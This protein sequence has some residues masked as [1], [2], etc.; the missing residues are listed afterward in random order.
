VSQ[1]RVGCAD[2]PP[3][4]VRERF[5][6]QLSYLESSLWL[7]GPVKP[8]TWKKWCTSPPGALGL[9]A[10]VVIT[11]PSGKGAPP[12]TFTVPREPHA[13]GELRDTPA[14]RDHVDLLARVAAEAKAS[15]VVFHTP[16]SFSPSQTNRDTVRRFFSE[17]APAEKVG[18]AL[19]VWRPDGLWE[20]RTAVALAAE[21]GIVCA[22]DPLILDPGGTPA[23]FYDDLPGDAVYFR[24]SGL[25]R[26]SRKLPEHELERLVELIA[27]F[28]RAWV[29]FATA[30][31]FRDARGLLQLIS[32]LVSIAESADAP[33]TDT[34]ADADDADLDDTDSDAEDGDDD[35]DLD[36]TD[37]D[38]E[39]DD[40]DAD[41]E[42]AD[43]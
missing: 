33:G 28:E 34:D 38:A 3:G 9:V 22:L 37:S 11:H 27:R 42:G 8:A 10:P 2:L 23:A 18:A 24:V 16:A 19:R 30:E 36:D 15:A 31:R 6:N 14:V 12:H 43:K 7:T 20:P 21:L 35:T 32:S 13:W 41:D 1:V 4:N 17:T 40:A 5:F 25:G 39:S 26:P 29:V